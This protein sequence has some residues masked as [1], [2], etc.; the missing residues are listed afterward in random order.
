ME[1]RTN[2]PTQLDLLTSAPRARSA[3]P[4]TSKQ[5]A[6]SVQNMRASHRMVLAMF[7]A[8]GEMTDETLAEYINAAAENTGVKR[9]SPSGVRSRRSEL[10]KP[11][12][13]RLNEIVREMSNTKATYHE[14]I[15]LTEQ[16]N[17][18]DR[19]RWTKIVSAARHRL[20]VEG[21]YS[22]LWDTGKRERMKTGRLAIVWGIAR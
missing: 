19:E 9:M 3:D 15:G 4:A 22:P 21:W 1:A 14:A 11:N 20:R 12:M 2:E 10:A 8:Y 6:A 5:A 7:R 16:G 17:A 13:D 18:Q